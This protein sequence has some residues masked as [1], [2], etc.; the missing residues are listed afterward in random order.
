MAELVYRMLVTL[1]YVS[2]QWGVKTSL[3]D[4]WTYY[5]I[6]FTSTVYG[7]LGQQTAARVTAHAYFDDVDLIKF[8]YKVTQ[9]DTYPTFQTEAAGWFLAYGKQQ[10][11][12]GVSSASGTT[13]LTYHLEYSNFAAVFTGNTSG[14]KST[15]PVNMTNVGLS[16]CRIHVKD[17]ARYYA[18]SFNWFALG[19]QQWGL[20]KIQP[21]GSVVNLN[22]SCDIYCISATSIDGDW[23]YIKLIDNTKF[24]LVVNAQ[25]AFWIC[26]GIADKQQWGYSKSCT[27]KFHLPFP[28]QVFFCGIVLDTSYGYEFGPDQLAPKDL[29]PSGFTKY[30]DTFPNFWWFAIGKQ[31]WGS[32]NPSPI[33]YPISFTKTVFTVLPILQTADG[34]N[35]SKN[36]LY[37]TSLTVNGFTIY[38][39]QNSYNW[40]AVGR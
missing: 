31:Q 28:S 19:F 23:P 32:N 37:V 5:P 1:L 24:K 34:G 14:D 15:S 21:P 18:D 4:S 39:P 30:R 8:H 33:T 29:N 40:L 9:Y 25:K 6:P 7:I 35:M 12:V 36:R 26:L 20:A 10:W 17:D 16:S 11:G 22:I 38:N 2:K 3:T 13:T 27:V